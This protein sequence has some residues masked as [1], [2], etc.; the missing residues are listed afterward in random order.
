ME[1]YNY[2][3]FFFDKDF[4]NNCFENDVKYEI[5]KNYSKKF[6]DPEFLKSTPKE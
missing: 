4:L 3:S 5:I 2:V 6:E 1:L